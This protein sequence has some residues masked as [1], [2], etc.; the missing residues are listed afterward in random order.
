[1]KKKIMLFALGIL[2]ILGGILIFRN[3]DNKEINPNDAIDY[4]KNLNSYSCDVN[5]HIKNS[6]QEIEKK[7]KQFYNKKFGHRLDIDDKRILL[8][9]ENDITVRD[10]N[11]NKQYKLDKNFDDVYKLSFIEEYIGL[12]YTN[13]DIESSFKTIKDREYQLINLTIP[14]NNRNLNKA[15]LYVNLENNNPEK[16]AIY[17]IKGKEMLSFLYKNFIPNAEISEEVFKK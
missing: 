1:M 13:Q 12:L 4:L 9:K 10:L 5:L 8:Y 14:G 16:I 17:D 6:K 2:L 15:I 3:K 7:C 11:N